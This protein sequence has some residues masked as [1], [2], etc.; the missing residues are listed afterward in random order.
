MPMYISA[1]KPLLTGF[2][3]T[4]LHAG[5]MNGFGGTTHLA[6]VDQSTGQLEGLPELSDVEDAAYFTCLLF[7][8]D[9]QVVVQTSKLGAG[10]PVVEKI[11]WLDQELSHLQCPYPIEHI[12][13]T[14]GGDAVVQFISEHAMNKALSRYEVLK[15]RSMEITYRPCTEEDIRALWWVGI[16]GCPPE[17]APALRQ[18]LT[19]F[20]DLKGECPPPQNGHLVLARHQDNRPPLLKFYFTPNPRARLPALLPVARP[21]NLPPLLV[22]VFAP[23]GPLAPKCADFGKSHSPFGCPECY[24]RQH[25]IQAG[26]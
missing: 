19:I 14:Y 17:L 21:K 10:V 12:E 9:R 5:R 2:G 6:H 8:P 22:R 24:R 13:F 16:A 23:H 15:W 7:Q 18:A 3:G 11:R 26:A 1:E 4:S 20:G 25:Q